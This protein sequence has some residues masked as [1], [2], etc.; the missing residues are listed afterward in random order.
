MRFAVV[1]LSC[2]LIC[3][4]ITVS[5]YAQS[6][7]VK[8]TVLSNEDQKPLAGVSVAVKG[9]SIGTQTDEKGN[10]S[11]TASENDVLVFSFTGFETHEVKASP[12]TP[13]DITLQTTS[14]KL[15]D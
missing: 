14:A 2:W 15:D 10:F 5:V 9:K 12:G 1:K 13:V 7:T 11:L 6:F 4:L 8:G 3:L